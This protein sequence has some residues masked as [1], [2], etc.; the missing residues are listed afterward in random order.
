MNDKSIPQ[1]SPNGEASQNMLPNVDYQIRPQATGTANITK[2]LGIQTLRIQDSVLILGD[3]K[4]HGLE[5]DATGLCW[6][7]SSASRYCAGRLNLH[8]AKIYLE[9]SIQIGDSKDNATEYPIEACIFGWNSQPEP[10]LRLTATSTATAVDYNKYYTTKITKTRYASSID[11]STLTDADWV[12][13]LLFGLGFDPN[14]KQT[15][16][17]IGDTDDLGTYTAYS[18][19]AKT[20]QIKLDFDLSFAEALGICDGNSG[21]YTTGEL[22]FAATGTT[23]TFTGIITGLCSDATDNSTGIFYWKGTVKP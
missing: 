16:M 8:E 2:D 10:S 22:Y 19:D 12:D 5:F 9:G 14:L 6:E 13:G 20:N 7:H 3:E 17:K 15:T 18:F 21:L 11:T 4:I 1:Q 23:N